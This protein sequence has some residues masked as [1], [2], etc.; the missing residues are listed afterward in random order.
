MAICSNSVNSLSMDEETYVRAVVN[1]DLNLLQQLVKDGVKV[2][3]ED[4][5]IIEKI[6][7]LK[8][9][10]IIIFLLDN[11]LTVY[12]NNLLIIRSTMA[13]EEDHIPLLNAIQR[14]VIWLP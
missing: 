13:M 2:N 12:T 14:H 5:D 1:N 4:S 7:E 9:Y 10:D 6:V 3:L 8:Y 11:G